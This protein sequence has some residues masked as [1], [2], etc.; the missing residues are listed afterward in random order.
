MPRDQAQFSCIIGRFFTKS[1]TQRKQLNYLLSS[2]LLLY[3]YSFPFSTSISNNYISSSFPL[4]AYFQLLVF[5]AIEIRFS[6]IPLNLN[7][8]QKFINYLLPANLK[9]DFQSCKQNIVLMI[10][11]FL[12]NSSFG[13]QKTMLFW[14]SFYITDKFSL[15]SLEVSPFLLLFFE[16]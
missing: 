4:F 6:F 14:L 16:S 2:L 9:V 15:I 10:I 8:T 7:V 11:L 1:D 13:F 12:T 5:T 3:S